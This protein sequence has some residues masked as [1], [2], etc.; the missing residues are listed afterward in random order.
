MTVSEIIEKLGG[1]PAIVRALGLPDGD[2]GAKRVRAWRTRGS[3]PAEYW[4]AIASYSRASS[5]DVTLEALAEAHAGNAL[6]A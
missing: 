3:I 2:V 4:A 1:A 5:L 6:A